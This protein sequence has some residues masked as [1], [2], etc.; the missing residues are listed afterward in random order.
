M[1]GLMR[2]CK[3][4]YE[5]GTIIEGTVRSQKYKQTG[6]GTRPLARKSTI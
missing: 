4:Q 1:N 2:L 5:L 3:G 6:T